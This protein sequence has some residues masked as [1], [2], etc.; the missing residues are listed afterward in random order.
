MTL[1]TANLRLIVV[2]GLDAD[3]APPLSGVERA[4]RGGAGLVQLRGKSV[5]DRVLVR[6]A[7]D[8]L[9]LCR[10][11]GVPLFVNDR[12]DIA[13][14]VR[15]AGAHVGPDD[16][17]PL[18]ARRVLEILA[19]GVSARTQDRIRRA[20]EAGATY[21]GVGALRASATKPSAPVL[22]FDG[23]AALAAT[24]SLPVVAVGGVTAE[25]VPRLRDSGVAGVAA[26]RAVLGR[27]DP[28]AAAREFIRAW[29][30]AP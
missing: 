25:D 6:A 21:V 3:G 5:P 24:T 8:L 19:L 14:A 4:I 1:S 9:A 10:E 18:E 11:A 2:A 17:P 13:L 28:E 7:R 12:P 16:L 20:E 15:A 23:I 22:G 27:E 30:T 29:E 26:A